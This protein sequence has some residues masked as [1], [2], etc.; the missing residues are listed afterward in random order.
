MTGASP[1]PRRVRCTSATCAPRCWPGCSPARGRPLPD[2]RRGPRRR[3]RRGPST[4]RASSPTSRALGLDSDEPSRAAVGARASATRT[5]STRL[6]RQGALYPCWCT[7]AEI[8]EAASAPHGAA[9]RGRLPRHLPAAERGGARRARAPSGRPPALR[10]APARR[11]SP[12]TDRLLGPR[13]G[14][15]DDLVVRRNDGAPAYNLAVV[16]R[17][18]RPGHRRGRPRRRPPRH[19]AAPDLRSRGALGLR[20]PSLRARAAHARA[21]RRAAGQAPRRGHAGRPH[22]AR[23]DAGRRCAPRWPR[24][25]GCASRARAAP[26]SSS[27]RAIDRR[28][29]AA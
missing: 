17:R 24:A 5:R 21:R 27:S 16:G 19:D 14:V 20:E 8:R 9:A 25:S 1:P 18:R 15:V 23:R 13:E 11:A 29:V 26:S 3:P 4:R 10:L 6:D 7:R 28:L 22:R 12:S 2:A